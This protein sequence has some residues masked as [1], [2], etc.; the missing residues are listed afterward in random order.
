MISFKWWVLFGIYFLTSCSSGNRGE[1]LFEQGKFE[2]AIAF[3]TDILGRDTNDLEARYNRGRA[4]E[5]FGATDKAILDYEFIL[6]KD[7][8]HLNARLSLAQIYYKQGEYSKSVVFSSGALK[9]HQ[10]SYHAHFLLARAK[11]HMGYTQA[12]LKGYN[13][14]IALKRDYG[15]AYLYRGALKSSMKITTACDDFRMALNLNVNGAEEA[16]NKYCN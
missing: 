16:L 5:E 10:S 9:F 12:A 6:E 4:Y 3:Y 8:R 13:A 1:E 15:D 2:S 11:H 14:A 7:E